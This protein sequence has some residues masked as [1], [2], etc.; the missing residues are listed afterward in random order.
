MRFFEMPQIV[1]HEKSLHWSE[2]TSSLALRIDL[3]AK[4][5]GNFMKPISTIILL[6]TLSAF[7]KTNFSLCEIID[8]LKDSTKFS[9]S[10]EIKDG[11][12]SASAIEINKNIYDNLFGKDEVYK[13]GYLVG[14]FKITNERIGIIS[15]IETFEGESVIHSYYLHIVDN[16]KI[17]K[18][19]KIMTSDSEV[20]VYDISSKLSNDF[21][22]ITIQTE[23]SNELNT[24]SKIRDTIFIAKIKIDLNSK[25]LDTMFRKKSFKILKQ[26]SQK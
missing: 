24:N 12:E 2:R 9:Y 8:Q 7:G 18:N 6:V 16:C 11:F 1:V 22:N 19:Y 14:K 5:Q 15:Y 26:P 17:K 3:A 4:R 13:K 20:I 23:S 21:K 10:N 25:K